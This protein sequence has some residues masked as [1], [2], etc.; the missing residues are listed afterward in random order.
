MPRTTP[1]VV[2]AAAKCFHF[3]ATDLIPQFVVIYSPHLGQYAIQS[4]QGFLMHTATVPLTDWRIAIDLQPQGLMALMGVIPRNTSSKLTP[5]NELP[6]VHTAPT[7]PPPA[8]PTE[9]P[10]LELTP[11]ADLAPAGAIPEAD[12]ASGT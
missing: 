10:N 1:D 7:D 2:E 11:D 6:V 9:P 8:A 3:N 4:R 12:N 5:T